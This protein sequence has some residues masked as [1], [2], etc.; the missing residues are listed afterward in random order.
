MRGAWAAGARESTFERRTE[1][2]RLCG[3]DD[4]REAAATLYIMVG[5]GLAHERD[6]PAASMRFPCISALQ[7]LGGHVNGTIIGQKMR[8]GA[9]RGPGA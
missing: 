7:R 6:N 9:A 8:R 2:R 3:A 4:R 1:G 5:G